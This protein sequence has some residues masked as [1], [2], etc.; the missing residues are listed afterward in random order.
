MFLGRPLLPNHFF[1]A[2]GI[3]KFFPSPAQ[4]GLGEA[5]PEDPPVKAAGKNNVGTSSGSSA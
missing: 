3:A 4:F 5:K 1:H 2:N